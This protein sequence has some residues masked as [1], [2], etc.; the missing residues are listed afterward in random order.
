MKI[1]LLI[2]VFAVCALGIARL[3]YVLFRHE[4]GRI[5]SIRGRVLMVL[6]VILIFGSAFVFSILS[7]WFRLIPCAAF[8]AGIVINRCTNSKYADQ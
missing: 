2:L 3:L 5:R 8:I 6:S 1:V 7:G 4:F